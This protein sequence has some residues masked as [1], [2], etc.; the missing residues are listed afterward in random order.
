[1]RV[2][3][4]GGLRSQH[5]KIRRW[6][7]ADNYRRNAPTIDEGDASLIDPLHDVLI[8]QNVAIWCHD[9]ARAGTASFTALASC[10]LSGRGITPHVDTY[11]SGPHEF[12]SADNSFRVGI[13]RIVGYGIIRWWAIDR[14]R[15]FKHEPGMGTAQEKLKRADSCQNPIRSLPG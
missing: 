3:K 6:I 1:M 12:D 13:E 14:G 2:R 9:N 5:R 8:G 11:D 10:R 15:V 4:R 7:A